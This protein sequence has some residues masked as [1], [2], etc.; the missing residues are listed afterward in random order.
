MEVSSLSIPISF[1][2]KERCF[3]MEILIKFNYIILSLGIVY[4]WGAALPL[5]RCKDLDLCASPTSSLGD[6]MY[7]KYSNTEERI[8]KNIDKKP[9]GCWDW[10]RYCG[11]YSGPR[12]MFNKKQSAVQRI[13]WEKYKSKIPYG[14][15]LIRTCESRKCCN[16]DHYKI[17]QERR[18]GSRLPIPWEKRLWKNIDKRSNSECWNWKRGKSLGYGELNVNQRPTGTHRLAWIS[19]NGKIKNGLHVLHKCN[20]P[21]C[22]NPSHLYLGTNVENARDRVLAGT[23]TRGE[24]NHG[25]KLTER[26][27]LEIREK[28]NY[29]R[30]NELAKEYGVYAS[31][32]SKIVNRVQWKHI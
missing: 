7:V 22:C 20:N 18:T 21:S 25:S 31:A 27:V 10:L 28:I 24:K 11:K 3:Y 32:I 5:N 15:V 14:W 30:G 16:P 4:S 17:S 19:I 8:F 12:I 29:M 6:S 1:F 2:H 23:S 26:Q 13:L 9:N